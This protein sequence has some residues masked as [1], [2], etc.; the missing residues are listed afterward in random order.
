MYSIALAL[1]EI[2]PDIIFH[3]AY[4][5]EDLSGSIVEGT[6]D[7]LLARTTTNVAC[8]FIYLSTDAVFDGGS[9][10]YREYDVP[11]PISAY[12]KAKR[13]AEIDVLKAHDIVVRTSLVYGFDP[14]DPRTAVLL[15]GLKSSVFKYK[16]F[17]DEIRS[18][19][20]VE[21]LCNALMELGQ[22]DQ[23]EIDI[24][25]LAGP[26]ALSRYDFAKKL[27]HLFGCETEGIPK[28]LLSESGIIHPRDVSLDVT[29]AEKI[30]K[31]K[32]R[33]VEEVGK[34]RQAES[35]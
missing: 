19:V 34:W 11:T 5:T 31:T 28:G 27:A 17:I 26:K 6:K 10:P 33:S 22:I 13:I 4:D 29:L 20:F 1:Q 3:L 24:I 32:M 35:M 2:K 23:A 21:D 16:Y 9:G 8:R 30:L 25:H 12:C 18:P 14:P 15:Q 7:L